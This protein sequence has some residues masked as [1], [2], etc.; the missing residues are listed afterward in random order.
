TRAPE[1]VRRLRPEVPERMARVLERMMAKDPADRYQSPAAV[2]EALAEWATATPPPPDPSALPDWPAAVRRVLGL[3]LAEPAI[4]PP[5]PSSA[6]PS[7]F[8]RRRAPAAEPDG[9]RLSPWLALV[10]VAAGLATAGFFAMRSTSAGPEASAAPPSA[11][12]SQPGAPGRSATATTDS[13]P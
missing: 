11:G 4:T 13:A 6:M 10:A 1:P 12:V 8:P 5:P 2:A 3:P 9:R 7:A